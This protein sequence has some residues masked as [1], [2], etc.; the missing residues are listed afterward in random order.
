MKFSFVIMLL[1][2]GNFLFAQKNTLKASLDNIQFLEEFQVYEDDI[3]CAGINFRTELN[4]GNSSYAYLNDYDKK[5]LKIKWSIKIADEY[6]NKINSVIRYKD[7]IYALVSQGEVEQR[8]KSVNLNLFIISLDGKIEDKVSIGKSFFNPS[9]IAANGEDLYFA[10]QFGDHEIYLNSNK[11]QSAIVQYNIQTKAIKKFSSRDYFEKPQR[12]ISINGDIFSIGMYL[13]PN[14]P[15]V[16]SY[17]KE[18]FSETSFHTTK[19][20]YFLD[21]YV[22][23]RILTIVCTFPGVYGDMNPYLK[24]YY[25]NLDNN[26]ITSIIISYKQLGWDDLSFNTFH[27]E[28]STWISIQESKSKQWKYILLD[29]KGKIIKELSTYNTGRSSE[30]FKIEE[31]SIVRTADGFVTISE[32]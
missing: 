19:S 1:T 29:N 28:A 23:N 4:D 31:N 32:L 10:Y 9:N 5:T 7:K 21:S 18:A 26:K 8:I 11:V 20:E 17:R 16:L 25:M 3:Y 2:L 12:T 6:S 30:R 14:Q 27:A 22:N 13:H 24:Y 15:N